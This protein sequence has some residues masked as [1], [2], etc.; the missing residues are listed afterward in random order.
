VLALLLGAMIVLAPL[1]I[2]LRGVLGTGI[3]WVDPLLR[4]L[5]LWVGLLGALAASRED[6]HISIDVVSRLLPRRARAATGA[7]TSL[8]TAAVAALVAYHGARFVASEREFGS[9]VFSGIPAWGLESI[10]PFAFA[11]IAL[12]SLLR[13][14]SHL[15]AALAKRTVDEERC[16]ERGAP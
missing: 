13:S 1:Q 14:V 16:P 8:A 2:A 15:R 11:A 5:V 7:V 9:A 4:V 12:R 3:A 6:R 10:I